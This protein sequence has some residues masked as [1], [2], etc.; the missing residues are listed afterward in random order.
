MMI[1]MFQKEQQERHE[2]ERRRP[3][4]SGGEASYHGGDRKTL[5]GDDTMIFCMM[6]ARWERAAAAVNN[7]VMD[8]CSSVIGRHVFFS[9]L[10]GVQ[11][12]ADSNGHRLRPSEM[13]A[14]V[15]DLHADPVFVERKLRRL[16]CLLV[17]PSS[18]LPTM[19]AQDR[20]WNRSLGHET[21]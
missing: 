17:N 19:L 8:N 7:A 4:R 16:I 10:G 21:R 13:E 11:F 12:E 5:L 6:M 20:V 9:R 18:S 15:V 3:S 1:T 14:C 2:I